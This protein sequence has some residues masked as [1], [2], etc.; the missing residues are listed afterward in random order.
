M[1]DPN[2][3]NLPTAS[4]GDKPKGY[5]RRLLRPVLLSSVVAFVVIYLLS[6]IYVVKPE[7][8]ALIT[9]FGKLRPLPALP[10]THYHLPYPIDRVYLFKP[11]EVKSVVVGKPLFVD[12]AGPEP[13]EYIGYYLEDTAER[14]FLTG[15]ENIIHITLNVQYKVGD[16]A[17]YLFSTTLADQLVAFAA[18]TALARAV[19]STGVDAL[20]TSGRQLVL[21]QVEE[22]AQGQLDELDAGVIIMRTSFG[23]ISPPS[24]VID[25][26][27]DVA[28]ALEDKDRKI[29]EARGNYNRAVALARGEAS[30]TMSEAEGQKT[31][32]INRA[33]GDAERLLATLN[34]Y[35]VSQTPHMTLLRLYLETIETIL[36]KMK[37]YVIDTAV[38]GA[39]LK[40]E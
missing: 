35:R 30:K 29:H 26:F 7:Q 4:S 12:D 28:S 11:N 10:G 19:A 5:A 31:S 38:G 21:A 9:R 13:S 18:E 27:K 8:Q 33:L 17:R 23:D 34:E 6:G 22:Q 32:T 20:L 24:P 40:R 16:P 39:G 36:P 14:A 1:N 2:T 3:A 37:K 15:D 25:A